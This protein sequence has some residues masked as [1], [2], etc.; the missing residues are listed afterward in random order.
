MVTPVDGGTPEPTQAR[1]TSKSR[2]RIAVFAVLISIGVAGLGF[3]WAT[4]PPAALPTYQD[5]VDPAIDVDGDDWPDS[6]PE[7][8]TEDVINIRDQIQEIGYQPMGFAGDVQLYFP[9]EDGRWRWFNDWGEVPAY[10]DD[11]VGG[12]G[13]GD[14][15]RLTGTVVEAYELHDQVYEVIVWR[16]TGQDQPP[17]P[18]EL[19]LANVTVPGT[20]FA[21]SVA[22]VSREVHVAHYRLELF[23]GE[24]GVDLLRMDETFRGVF[25][26]FQDRGSLDFVD[27]GDRVV[28]RDLD[29]GNY[30]LVVSY[31]GDEVARHAFYV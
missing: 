8:G 23:R 9:Y 11:D 2:L 22:N 5:I 27:A 6:W 25:M 13:P 20:S 4:R 17:A 24:Y 30:T 1:D 12:F 16:V 19:I 14:W 31:T 26:E 3:W 28:F 21:V 29:P 15:I 18:P 7:F 10:V